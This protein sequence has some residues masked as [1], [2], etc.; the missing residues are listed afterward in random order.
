MY[1]LTEKLK[2]LSAIHYY[3]VTGRIWKNV[4]LNV[5]QTVLWPIDRVITLRYTMYI[6]KSPAMFCI[7]N[8]TKCGG[9]NYFIL[10][11][12]TSSHFPCKGWYL[13][14]A[15]KR[16][17]LSSQIQQLII[18]PPPPLVR[19]GGAL[20]LPSLHASDLTLETMWGLSNEV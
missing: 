5:W 3:L 10:W 13:I 9:L 18:M 16:L 15:Q 11:R 14:C 4:R 12:K 7:V 20:P 8:L 19:G 17:E 1:R 2:K 6:C